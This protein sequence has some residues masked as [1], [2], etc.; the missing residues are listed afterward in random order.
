MALWEQAAMAQRDFRSYPPVGSQQRATANEFPQTQTQRK[1]TLT[2][3]GQVVHI[4]Q[5]RARDAPSPPT[6]ASC[7]GARRVNGQR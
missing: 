1:T 7:S 5:M 6:H 3:K 2:F 4:F